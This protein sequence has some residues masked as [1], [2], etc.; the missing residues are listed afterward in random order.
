MTT[1]RPSPT[2]G[3]TRDAGFEIGVSRTLDH[4]P[5]T[6]W[7][8]LTSRNGIRRWLGGGLDLPAARGDH[9]TAPDGTTGEVRSFHPLDRIRLTW[10]P[11]DWD[12]A[13]IVQV[14]IAD[15]GGRTLLRFHQERLADPDERARQRTHWAGVMDGVMADL[16]AGS[17]SRSAGDR[18]E[19]TTDRR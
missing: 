15:R 17:G 12:H 5:S 18:G 7:T 10:R 13:S 1:A 19:V 8:Y 3:L 2:V 16:A 9:Y 11:V 6:V 4:P 14:A